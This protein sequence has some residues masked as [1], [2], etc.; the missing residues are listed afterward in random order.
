MFYKVYCTV[1]SRTLLGPINWIPV[2][3]SA[4]EITFSN[5]PW[6]CHSGSFFHRQ[7][8]H[9]NT[10]FTSIT[11]CVLLSTAIYYLLSN[12]L[13]SSWNF[14]A[15]PL[16]K[17][18]TR[19]GSTTF[20]DR[21]FHEQEEAT[22]GEELLSSDSRLDVLSTPWILTSLLGPLPLK[23]RRSLLASLFP[24]SAYLMPARFARENTT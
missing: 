19:Y 18:I 7:W 6:I 10:L 23:R 21:L 22:G 16:A 11:K 8:S 9:L 2:H 5:P 12:Q 15:G 13:V 24:G 4:T 17:I 14:L 3:L 1:S 20:S